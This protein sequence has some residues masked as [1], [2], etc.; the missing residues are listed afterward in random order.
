ML[1]PHPTQRFVLTFVVAALALSF[2]TA[3]VADTIYLKNGRQIRS[4]QVRIEG[5]RVLFIQ[6]GGEV[7]LPMSIVDRIEQDASVGPS[8]TPPPPP[9]ATQPEENPDQ[10]A[11]GDEGADV[12][13]EQ[14]RD[15]WQ[16]QV[17][18]IEAEREQV[19]LQIEDLRR[20]E[21]AFLFSHRSTAE[22]RQSI[23][24]A[25]QRLT[26]L[27]QEMTDLQ[28]EA[29]RQGVPPGWLRLEPGGGEG[30]GGEG[31]SGGSGG[32]GGG[33]GGSGGSVG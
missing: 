24:A 21:R 31:G 16:E 13:P 7:A 27:D 9:E 12:P 25:Q 20:Q 29:R 33:P 28:N 26:E 1:K 22:T 11:A 32:S 14:T 3:A 23:E 4:S 15:Y 8:A 19:N 17:R 30:G 18:S 6:Y 5:D 2:A 10:P